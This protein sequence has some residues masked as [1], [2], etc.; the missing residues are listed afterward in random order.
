VGLFIDHEGQ[1]KAKRVGTGKLGKKAADLAATK[2]AACR[3][4]RARC[5][6]ATL[7]R[8]WAQSGMRAGEA[9]GL[10]WHPAFHG[11]TQSRALPYLACTH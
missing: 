8:L 11:R 4:A 7:L 5:G 3:G 9:C 10:Q 6:L 2:I 1:R